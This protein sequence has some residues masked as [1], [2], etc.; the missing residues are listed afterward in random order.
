MPQFVASFDFPD[1]ADAFTR[2]YLECAEWT[3][4]PQWEG[5]G[6]PE[7]NDDAPIPEGWS[8]EFLTRAKLDCIEFQLDNAMLLAA[9]YARGY[10]EERAGHDFWLTR[11]HHGAGYWDREEL[12]AGGLGRELTAAANLFS[13]IDTYVGDDGLVYA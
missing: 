3:D 10:S 12:E 8:A 9:A 5:D 2:G 1:D 11:N 6:M 4:E 13:G 7:D